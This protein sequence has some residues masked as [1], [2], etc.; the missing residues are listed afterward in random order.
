M[1]EHWLPDISGLSELGL[2]VNLAK[3]HD[4][5]VAAARLCRLLG[6]FACSR[7]SLVGHPR[8]GAGPVLVAAVPPNPAVHDHLSPRLAEAVAEAL[9]R[10]FD[11]DLIVRHHPTA[12]LRD[13]EP[14][15]RRS[16]AALAGYDVTRP[17][18]GATVILVDDVIM[19]GTT[20]G[21]IAELLAEAGAGR[22][23][24]VV[25]SRTRRR[26]R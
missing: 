3:D 13:T 21:L 20:V 18:E 12:R 6:D 19:T 9:G 1:G 22:V 16:T 7:R 8:R 15:R 2:L 14:S 26:H 24:V 4:D 25:A 17:V 11:H 23:E 5:A 10:R